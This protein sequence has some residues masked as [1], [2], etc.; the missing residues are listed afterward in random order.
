MLKVS[1]LN[2]AYDDHKVLKGVN[3]E[4]LPGEIHGLLG[5]NGAGK[6]TLFRAIYGF[7]KKDSGTF[8]LDDIPLTNKSVAFLETSPFFYSY[9]KGKEYLNI[10]SLNNENFDVDNWNRIFDLPLDELVDTYSTGMKKKL[11]FLGIIA[12]DR[13]VMILDEPFSGVD[14]E[15]N[16]KI[17]QI[18]KRLKAQGKTIILSSHILQSFTDICDRISVLKA[19]LILKTYLKEE[20]SD[21]ETKLRAEINEGVDTILNDLMD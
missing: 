21:L 8:E 9:M 19:G 1:N 13:P 7:V 3:F 12:L 10:V 15:S 16:E 4:C 11:A 6:T 18:L 20:F 5:M 17:F 2:V 14:V